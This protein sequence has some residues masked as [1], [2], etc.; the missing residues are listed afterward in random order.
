M[1]IIK[2]LK[3]EKLDI[4]PD[5]PLKVKQGD[6][7][8]YVGTEGENGGWMPH[9]HISVVAGGE[10]NFNDNY[11]YTTKKDYYPTRWKRKYNPDFEGTWSSIR[12]PGVAFSYEDYSLNTQNAKLPKLNPTTGEKIKGEE[13]L[14]KQYS[15]AIFPIQNQELKD[16]LRNPNILFKLRGEDTYAFSIERLFALEK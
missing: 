2:I 12:V 1:L 3:Q 9:V 6:I 5:N 10:K 14:E 11:Y 13:N 15:Y 8:G 4:T 7:I 16:G